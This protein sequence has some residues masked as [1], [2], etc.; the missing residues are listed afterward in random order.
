MNQNFIVRIHSLLE[1]EGIKDEK[2]KIDA[3][4]EGHEIIEFIHFLRIQF[5]HKTGNFNPKNQ[6]EQELRQ[7]LFDF[8]KIDPKESLPTQFPLDK[9]RVIKPIVEGTKKYVKAFWNK[10]R[11]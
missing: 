4:I 5:A 10:N 3:D 11:K 9:N 7:R 6:K 8:F 1:Y 2:T